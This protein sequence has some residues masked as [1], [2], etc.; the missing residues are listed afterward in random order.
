[1]EYDIVYYGYEDFGKKFNKFRK[2]K[3][4]DIILIKYG[5]KKD[6]EAIGTFMCDNEFLVTSE[7]A[8]VL[9]EWTYYHAL[10]EKNKE[11]KRY[12]Q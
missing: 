3:Q 7:Y 8:G 4:K 12:I 1:M 5:A 6:I 2:D 10:V 9:G 11:Y